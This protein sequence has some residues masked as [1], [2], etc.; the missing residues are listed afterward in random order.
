MT[1]ILIETLPK[2]RK[3]GLP[4]GYI[5]KE[6]RGTCMLEKIVKHA[7]PGLKRNRIC[8][9]LYRSFTSCAGFSPR[10][11]LYYQKSS[12][13]LRKLK[14]IHQGQRCFII[15]TGPSLNQTNLSLLKDEIVFGVNTLYRGLPQF[16]IKCHYY[17]ISDVEV[18]KKHY[19]GIL[20]VD[21][22]LF[23]SS[24]AAQDY[25]SNLSF[26][27]K[28]Q[29]NEPIV[30][31]ELGN[32]RSSGWLSRDLSVG[33]YWG[34]TIIIDIGLQAAYHL[35][36]GKVYLLGCDCDYTGLH[37]FDGL[38]TENVIQDDWPRVFAAYEVCKQAYEEDGR[39]IINATVG[40]KLEVF[41]RQKLEDIILN[42]E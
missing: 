3:L 40:G 8:R 22:V 28:Y 20:G 9:E 30:I 1:E 38:P 21:A 31:K 36:F 4:Y 24:H 26:Y 11:Y 35:G 37:R 42:I 27:K 14:D 33:A 19:E 12:R 17:A 39:E 7:P 34:S 15:G 41:K 10:K 18:W 2:E 29:K 23:I 32:I 5:S 13:R 6:I 25:L 16:G